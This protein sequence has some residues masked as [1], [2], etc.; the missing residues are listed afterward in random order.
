[1]ENTDKKIVILPDYVDDG[2][3]AK[4]ER[5]SF[6]SMKDYMLDACKVMVSNG[7]DASSLEMVITTTLDKVDLNDL[8][9]MYTALEQYCEILDRDDPKKT[10]YKKKYSNVATPLSDIE[11]GLYNMMLKIKAER[12]D[13]FYKLYSHLQKLELENYLHN[14]ALDTVGFRDLLHIF[15]AGM[16]HVGPSE[17]ENGIGSLYLLSEVLTQRF[18]DLKEKY[19]S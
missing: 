9:P 16:P 1:M 4:L 8:E 2:I 7:V 14:L 10:V 19:F 5:T 6:K 11:S 17:V 3:K 13:S 12:G 18:V 15:I